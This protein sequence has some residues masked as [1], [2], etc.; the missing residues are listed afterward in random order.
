MYANLCFAIL[1]QIQ[2]NIS[3]KPTKTCHVQILDLQFNLSKRFSRCE[4][5]NDQVMA[6]PLSL[7]L[8]INPELKNH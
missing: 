1:F 6:Y 8:Y 7:V 3:S 5:F 4:R 2:S